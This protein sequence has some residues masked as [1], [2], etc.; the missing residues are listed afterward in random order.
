MTRPGDGAAPRRPPLWKGSSSYNPRH[1]PPLHLVEA[2]LRHG[3]QAL[4]LSRLRQ[5][6]AVAAARLLDAC[7]FAGLEVF[8]G[9]TFEAQL[10]FLGEDPFERLAAIRQAVAS[11]PLVATLAGQALVGHRHVADDVVDAFIAELATRGVDVLRLHDPLND[12]ANLERPIAAARKAKRRVEGM[13]VVGDSPDGHA[14]DE[15]V[16]RY[17]Q[18]LVELGCD[19]LVL[20]D[21]LGSLGAGRAA[22]LVEI[23]ATATSVP[24]GLSITAQTGQAGLAYQAAA[25]AGA[26]SVDVCVAALAGGASFPAAE[27]VVSGLAGTAAETGLDL[28]P[29]LAVSTYLEEIAPLYAELADPVAWR[30]DTAALRGRLPLSA[31]GSAL[32]E[33]RERDAV[34]RLDDVEEEL[35]RVRTE[36]GR[37]PLMSPFPEMIASQAVYNVTDGDR[38][39]TVSQEVKDYCLGLFGRPPAPIAA[40]VRRLVNGRE[41]PIT[42]R[43]ADLL[44]PGLPVA[45]RELRRE[46]LRHDASARLLHALFPGDTVAFLRGESEVELL[47]DESPPPPEASAET[48]PGGSADV[49]AAAEPPPPAEEMREL[50]V[51]VDGQSYAVRVFG[52]GLASGGG[53]PSTTGAAVSTGPAAAGAGAGAVTAPMQGLILKV[54][55]KKGDAVGVGDVVA[56]LEAMKMQNDVVAH[57]AGTVSDVFVKEGDVVGPKDAILAIA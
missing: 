47:G 8:G 5:R 35:A 25:A 7:G 50:R 31:M 46:S 29:I 2:S 14:P 16:S 44:E 4:L 49:A 15:M 9:S 43:P 23:V 53:G 13:I 32:R 39:A 3:Q 6:H 12:A 34:D 42:C 51:E 26:D 36:L 55:V 11:T 21:P 24:V 54:A 48:A 37:P 40:E 28:G 18:R 56:V 41:E 22:A 33:L 27:A 52:H 10:R 57:R 1:M 30:Y 38:Y 19:R 17:A 45:E 20:H